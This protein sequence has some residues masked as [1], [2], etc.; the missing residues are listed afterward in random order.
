M[1]AERKI[2]V[3]SYTRMV[4]SIES[5]AEKILVFVRSYDPEKQEKSL[6]EDKLQTIEEMRCLLHDTE[7]KLYGV[8]KEDE[9]ESWQT[10]I[11]KLEDLF[12]ESRRL[13]RNK[14]HDMNPPK[15][16]TATVVASSSQPS[17]PK[18]PDIPL[19]RF[20]G[21]TE[22]WIS[23]KNQ[24]CAL[25]K[26]RDGLSESEKLFYL[27]AAIQDGATHHVLLSEVWYPKL[28]V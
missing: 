24:F 21:Q 25:V 14:L 8:I 27:K 6:L 26:R 11:E 22:D 7:V 13:I 3:T 10:T 5:R 20:S 15:P 23:F 17:H 19:P 2:L 12:D 1:A 9:V 28:R 4:V 16:V 18:L